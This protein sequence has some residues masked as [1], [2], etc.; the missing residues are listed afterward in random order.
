MYRVDQPSHASRPQWIPQRKMA[1]TQLSPG[2]QPSRQQGIQN[3][4]S[5]RMPDIYA[6]TRAIPSFRSRQDIERTGNLPAE[7]VGTNANRTQRKIKQTQTYKFHTIQPL[8]DIKRAQESALQTRRVDQGEGR[9]MQ[10]KM[11]G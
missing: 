6:F 1:L 5:F 2:V 8:D 9:T 3:I 11:R 7:G 10:R 4:R